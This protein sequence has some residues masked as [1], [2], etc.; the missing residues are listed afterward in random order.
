MNHKF[1]ILGRRLY[2]PNLGWVDVVRTKKNIDKSMGNFKNIVLPIRQDGVKE[3]V[4]SRIVT[5]YKMS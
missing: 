5:L 1:K 2:S 4:I 3:P